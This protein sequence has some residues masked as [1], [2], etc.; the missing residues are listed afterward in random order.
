MEDKM[1]DPSTDP[2]NQIKYERDGMTFSIVRQ[3]PPFY[4]IQSTFELPERYKGEY[5]SIEFAMNAINEYCA[6]NKEVLA[7]YMEAVVEANTAADTKPK[8][9]RKVA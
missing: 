7:S 6:K 9:V 3:D 8:K 1:Y 2:L 4:R 5:T